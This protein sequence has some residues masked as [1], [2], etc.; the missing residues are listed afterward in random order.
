MNKEQKSVTFVHSQLALDP[1]V[2]GTRGSSSSSNTYAAGRELM[3]RAPTGAELVRA[4]W[5][6]KGRKERKATGLGAVLVQ[7][8]LDEQHQ[9]EMEVER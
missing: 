1:L 4:P 8:V 3:V 2:I 7:R 6:S 9:G 5:I